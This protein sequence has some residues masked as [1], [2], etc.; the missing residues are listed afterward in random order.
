MWTLASIFLTFCLKL[1]RLS[2]LIEKVPEIS[3]GHF[4]AEGCI[5]DLKFEIR[6]LKYQINKINNK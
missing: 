6:S 5:D 3:N 4:G 1:Y 2:G